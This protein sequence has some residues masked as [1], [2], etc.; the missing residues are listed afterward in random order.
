MAGVGLSRAD[1]RTGLAADPAN[2]SPG[3]AGDDVFDALERK[4][5]DDDE[6][7]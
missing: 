1:R 7:E 5:E 6:G 4:D 3:A 2:A